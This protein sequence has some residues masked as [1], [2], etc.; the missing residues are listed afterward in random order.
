VKTPPWSKIDPGIRRALR[1]LVGA[2]VFTTESC[3]G[4]RGHSFPEPTIRFA[5]DITEGHR[6]L[7]VALQH[8]LKVTELRRVW[9][10]QDG[11]PTGPQWEIVFAGRP[12]VMGAMTK[13]RKGLT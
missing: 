7:G 12:R 8:R 10:I 3:E 11:E 13:K 9:T 5:G 1:V 2:G 6:V 4:G